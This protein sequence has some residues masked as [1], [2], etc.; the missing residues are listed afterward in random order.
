MNSCLGF[1]ICR[2]RLSTNT[3]QPD[4]IDNMLSFPLCQT[5][6]D[7]GKTAVPASAKSGPQRQSTTVTWSL[8]FS[9]VLGP[10]PDTLIRSSTVRNGPCSPR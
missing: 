8:I 4:D 1:R 9:S 6:N 10:M 3:W 5:R 2:E 7:K